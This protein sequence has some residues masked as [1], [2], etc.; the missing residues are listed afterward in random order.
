MLEKIKK[1]EAYYEHGDFES[2]VAES[3]G[4]IVGEIKAKKIL[5]VLAIAHDQIAIKKNVATMRRMQKIAE[6]YAE[7]LIVEFPLWD[8]GHF[9]MGVILQHSGDAEKA[10]KFYKKALLL[11]P[12][13]SSYLLSLGNG[14]RAAKN[15][16]RAQ[17]WYKK[18]LKIKNIKHLA[19]VNLV[20]LYEELGNKKMIKK[21]ATESLKFLKNKTDSFSKIQKERMDRIL[22]S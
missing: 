5:Y 4:I 14:F 13:N 18:A 6:T 20:S 7:I 21:Y 8:K 15:F 16:K 12:K 2:I 3:K 1:I 22:S 10:I 17:F 19:A 9:I 11:N